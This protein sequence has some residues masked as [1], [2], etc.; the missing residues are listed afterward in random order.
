M[1]ERNSELLVRRGDVYMARLSDLK[2]GV[3][4]GSEQGGC[5]PVL[6]IQNNCGNKYSTTTI[7]ACITS[8]TTK[9]PIPTHVEVDGFGNVDRNVVMFE[10]IKT[11][12]KERLIHKMGY[13]PS[14]LWEDALK[15]SV[16]L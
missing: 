15:E 10:Q 7:V 9:R 13:L 11:I 5:R 16:G 6:V 3:T 2:E 12:D 8:R 1:Y 14:R 4:V